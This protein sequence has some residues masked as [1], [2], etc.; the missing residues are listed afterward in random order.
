MNAQQDNHAQVRSISAV[1]KD[2]CHE[3]TTQRDNSNNN[4]NSNNTHDAFIAVD[5]I[6]SALHKRGFGVVL[7]FLSLPMALPFPVPP[8]LNVMLSLPL[9]FLTTQQI[10]A[11]NTV[12]LPN[13]LRMKTVNIAA[14]I[15]V[16][17]RITPFLTKLEHLTKPRLSCLT[18]PSAQRITGMLGTIMALSITV[19]LPLT[20]TVPSLSIA[21][22]ALGILMRDGIA[23]LTGALIGMLWVTMLICAII[24]FGP[25]GIEIVKNLIKSL[26][27]S[28]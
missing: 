15:S 3:L 18:S 24:F 22:M 5:D 1:L 9:L 6:L 11:V 17:N 8:V 26:L 10:L 13:F 19:P 23:V 28:L 2:F 20:N 7:L 21:V 12:W 14:V 27:Y 25:E 16:I 4:N